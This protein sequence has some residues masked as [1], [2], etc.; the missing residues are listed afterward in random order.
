MNYLDFRRKLAADPEFGAKFKDCRTPEALV[1]AAA[2][3]GFEFTLDDIRNNT[4]ILP[5][6]LEN[7]AGGVSFIAP[8]SSFINSTE[9]ISIPD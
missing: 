4:E 7:V 2:K 9:C 6:E 3:E 1:E 8:S 5:E